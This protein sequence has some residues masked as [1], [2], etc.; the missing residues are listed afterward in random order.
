M[1]GSLGIQ[2]LVCFLFRV[3]IRSVDSALDVADA[4]TLIQVF[5]FV[6]VLGLSSNFVFPWTLSS[7]RSPRIVFQPA[8]E[9]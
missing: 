4:K 3:N 9:V 7:V 6:S 1:D 8:V 5:T 2:Q